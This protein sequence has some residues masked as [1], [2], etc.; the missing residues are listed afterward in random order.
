[1][2]LLTYSVVHRLRRWEIVNSQLSCTNTHHKQLGWPLLIRVC[3]LLNGRRVAIVLQDTN[4]AGGL[5]SQKDHSGLGQ[6]QAAHY[7]PKIPRTAAASSDSSDDSE[8]DSDSDSSTDSSDLSDDEDSS[9]PGLH[10]KTGAGG[11]TKV[12]EAED[13]QSKLYR[14][15]LAN[16]RKAVEE[17]G[18]LV[19]FL[20]SPFNGL[21]DERDI[22]INR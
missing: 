21:R 20:S 3:T 22:F 4:V 1:M 8:S 14:Q 9:K 18:Q 12:S 7:L 10:R 11:S 2:L 6:N 16:Q 15:S 17:S 5:A 13:E 19:I